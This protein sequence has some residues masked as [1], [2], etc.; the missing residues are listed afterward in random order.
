LGNFQ[1]VPVHFSIIHF[2][3]RDKIQNYYVSTF[4]EIDLAY[5]FPFERLN[6][7][8]A[9]SGQVSRLIPGGFDTT[10]RHLGLREDH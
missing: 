9:N 6:L 7:F 4:L 5:P 1:I 3:F 10:H 2:S 8:L